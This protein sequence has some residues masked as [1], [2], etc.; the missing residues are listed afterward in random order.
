MDGQK[1]NGLDLGF[2]QWYARNDTVGYVYIVISNIPQQD[3]INFDLQSV[4]LIT[5]LC[6][7]FF[8]IIFF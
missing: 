7:T 5:F 6:L 3:S 4:V 1:Y 8:W 2:E